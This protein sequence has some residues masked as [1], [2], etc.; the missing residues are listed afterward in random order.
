VPSLPSLACHRSC[1]EFKQNE[2]LNFDLSYASGAPTVL[3]PA[4]AN[5]LTA[6][7]GQPLHLHYNLDDRDSL[8]IRVFLGKS[9]EIT[10]A[11]DCKRGPDTI[12]QFCLGSRWFMAEVF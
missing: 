1:G 10:R 7:T 8:S 9:D 11:G 5:E 4:A 2:M 6:F 3:Q 12:L